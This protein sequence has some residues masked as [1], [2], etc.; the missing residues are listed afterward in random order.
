MSNPGREELRQGELAM[1]VLPRIQ[2]PEYRSANGRVGLLSR[3]HGS[4]SPQAQQAR[5]ERDVIGIEERL[6]AL[7]HSAPA[8]SPE[9]LDRLRRLLP[10]VGA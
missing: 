7:V 9:Q 6:S 4:D 2:T 3:I 1:A 5:I 10:P 8:P